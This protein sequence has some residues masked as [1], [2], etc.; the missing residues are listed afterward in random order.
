MDLL[1]PRC[2]GLD[3]HPRSESACVR[4]AIT[5]QATHEVRTFGTSTRELQTMAHWLS[6]QGC[7]H[8]AMESTGVYWKPV[9]HVLEGRFELV[10]ANVLYQT[11]DDLV[12][13]FRKG[14]TRVTDNR[15]TW[16]FM[17]DHDDLTQEIHKQVCNR[18]A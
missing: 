4:L 8:V 12:A 7:T 15:D 10:L 9:W 14:V 11:L 13:A 18:A 5:S 17:F 3:V 6:S 16:A 1:Y 2:A